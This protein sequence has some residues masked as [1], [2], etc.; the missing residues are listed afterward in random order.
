VLLDFFPSRTLT[1]YLIKLFASRILAVLVR[2]KKIIQ[3]ETVWPIRLPV[4]GTVIDIRR[5][6]AT[7]PRDPGVS[8]VGGTRKMV[9]EITR[10]HRRRHAQL[11]KV[12]DARGRPRLRFRPGESRKQHRR[13]NSDDR[14]DD[15]EFD[16]SKRPFARVHTFSF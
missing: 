15:Q 3:R 13:E 10:V 5:T 1:M 14:D 11:A 9:I 2:Q 7:K 8:R 12:V 6:V 4:F 16:Q